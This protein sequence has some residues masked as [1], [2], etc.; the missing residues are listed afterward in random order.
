MF[1]MLQPLHEFQSA[2]QRVVVL[3]DQDAHHLK[4][5]AVLDSD[6]Q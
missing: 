3:G 1:K 5:M 2:R 4:K 6:G